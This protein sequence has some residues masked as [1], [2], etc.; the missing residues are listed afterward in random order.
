M[1]KS[2]SRKLT[3]R[4]RTRGSARTAIQ[5]PYIRA[6]NGIV[7]EKGY[8]NKPNATGVLQPSEE[9]IVQGNATS[10]MYVAPIHNKVEP[11][12]MGIAGPSN[13][14]I[15]KELQNRQNN[16]EATASQRPAEIARLKNELNTLTR[17]EHA[18]QLLKRAHE[19][20]AN[21]HP[22]NAEVFR[23]NI[24]RAASALIGPSRK[25]GSRKNK[26]KNRKT[27]RKL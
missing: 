19:E 5:P 24:L 26:R 17:A 2:K 22:N 21:L 18:V 12:H 10:P 7:A 6:P 9:H 8:A 4:T 23:G 13:E 1:V 27:H 14:A 15:M 3:R 16:M 25:G 20:A 11:Y